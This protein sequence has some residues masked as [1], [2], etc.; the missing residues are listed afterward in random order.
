MRQTFVT[1]RHPLAL[2][3]LALPL[4][5]AWPATARAQYAEVGLISA[6]SPSIADGMPMYGG[7]IGGGATMGMRVSGAMR[8]TAFN[9]SAGPGEPAR[10]MAMM[11][12]LD[13]TY[14][15]RSSPLLQPIASALFG[16]SPMAFV[17]AGGV[18]QRPEGG[19]LRGVPTFSYGGGVSRTLLGGLGLTTEARYRAMVRGPDGSLP[20][21]FRPGWEYRA[22]VAF[23]FGGSRSRGNGGLGGVLGRLPIPL[24]GG[25]AT[26]SGTMGT[27]SGTTVV[28][29]GDDYLGV[30]YVYGGTTPRGFDCSGFVQYV[31][32]RNGVRLPRTSRQQAQVGR[33]VTTSIA[34]LKPGDLL[35]FNTEGSRIDHV[36]MYAGRNRILHSSSSGGGVRFDDLSTSRGRWFVSKIV[37]AR[38]VTEGG[39][40]LVDESMLASLL[41]EAVKSFD[42]PDRAPRP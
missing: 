9:R 20:E 23:R 2:P 32:D 25:G 15:T 11:L 16:F 8:T 42:G 28:A 41:G 1:S 13:F 7:S 38:R 27:A 30:P 5:I 39:R 37:S 34:S 36:A 24:P 26:T 6:W 4:A 40:S 19:E 29:T 14:D 17:G 3:L 10:P 22:G 18:A 12:D 33:G 21:G 35:F 31:F